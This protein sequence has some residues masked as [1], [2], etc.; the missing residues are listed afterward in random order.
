[1][2]IIILF[3]SF[4]TSFS[5]INPK[6]RNILANEAKAVDL[7]KCLITDNSWNK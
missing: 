2:T 5:E 6:E 7:A 3:F 1:M 4:T